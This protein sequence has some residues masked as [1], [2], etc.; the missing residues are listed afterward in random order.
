MS[1]LQPVL[2]ETEIV[3]PESDGQPMAENTLQ[4]RWIETLVGGLRA[5]FHDDPDVFV[6]GDLLWY[7]IQGDNLTRAAPD[8]M[9]V[10]GRPKG[11]RGSY[12]QWREGGIAPQVV[13]EVTSPG[14]TP[15][16][17]RAKALFY[18]RHGVEEYYVYDPDKVRLEV[19]LREG[20]LL[21]RTGA[22][23]GWVSPRLNIRFDLSGPELVVTGP[24]GTPF[25]SH[26]EEVLRANQEAERAARA[27]SQAK[28]EAERAKREGERADQERAR[29][30]AAEQRLRELEDRLRSLGHGPQT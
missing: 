27:T 3:Y 15:A 13:F 10:F 19:W 4:F 29:A 14:N 25:R 18:E 20:S 17:M 8:A 26:E 5:V 24:D 22:G 11:D 1:P 6:A 30:E 7:P 2:P 28:R 21:K 16:E 23:H 9:V 12:L